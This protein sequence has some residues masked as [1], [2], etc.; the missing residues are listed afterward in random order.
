MTDPITLEIPF[1]YALVAIP[2]LFVATTIVICTFVCWLQRR[3][4]RWWQRKLAE[5]AKRK[6]R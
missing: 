3:S 1:W 4:D 6:Q 2:V 5:I